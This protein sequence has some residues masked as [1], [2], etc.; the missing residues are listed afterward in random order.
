VR[1]SATSTI[2]NISSKRRRMNLA[3]HTLPAP[4]R[5]VEYIKIMTGNSSSR[6]PVGG[7]VRAIY[8]FSV[9]LAEKVMAARE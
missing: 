2:G 8:C 4:Q 1:V 7:G 6:C 3:N 5:R 9:A